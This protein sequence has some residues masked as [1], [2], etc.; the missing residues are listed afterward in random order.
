MVDRHLTRRTRRAL[1]RGLALV[2]L[3]APLR[4]ALTAEP[5]S[6]EALFKSLAALGERRASFVERR[7]ST[8]LR[9]PAETRGTLYFKTPDLL[10]RR[11]V[12]P[13]AETVRI[14]GGHVTL[15]TSGPDG[16]PVER[17]MQ[18]ALAPQLGWLAQ[19]L[20][21]LLGGQLGALRQLYF[22]DWKPGP[23]GWRMELAPR[24]EQVAT[25]VSQIGVTGSGASIEQIEISEV[26]GDR[27]ELT[28]TPVR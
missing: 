23:R 17:K 16:R 6:V 1:L 20:R 4:P 21:A 26:S 15:V 10:E 27:V 11:V 8:L 7:H 18:L 9:Q 2:A 3:A 25:L 22:V 5:D 24:D 12:A 14:E 19:T 13:R 28:L